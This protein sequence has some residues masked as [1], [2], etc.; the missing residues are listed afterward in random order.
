MPVTGLKVRG[1]GG[2]VERVHDKLEFVELEF[3]S[4]GVVKVENN[5]FHSRLTKYFTS[6][7]KKSP[8]KTSVNT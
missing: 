3:N 1:V 6:D 8:C 5:I 4:N 7:K 2:G